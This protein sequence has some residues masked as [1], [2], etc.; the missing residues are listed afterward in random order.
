MDGTSTVTFSYGCGGHIV[1]G[2]AICRMN[3]IL[4]DTLEG[5]VIDTVLNYYAPYLVPFP[6]TLYHFSRACR[7]RYAA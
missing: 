7:F 3:A 5:L 6:A 1:K 4:Q 2:N